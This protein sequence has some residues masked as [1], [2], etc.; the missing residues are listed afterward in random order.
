MT[1]PKMDEQALFKQLPELESQ[2]GLEHVKPLLERL[3]L[4]SLA[5]GEV[6]VRDQAPID[7]L[8]LVLAGRLRLSV[9][10]GEHA[11]Q[12][13]EVGPG[14][15]VGEL[16]YFS[17]VHLASSTVTACGDSEIARLSYR[18]FDA[19]LDEDSVAVCRL[20]HGFIQMLMRRLAVTANNPVIDPHGEMLLLGDLSVPWSELAQQPHGMI[21]FL[22]K[23]LGV[24]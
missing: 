24:H 11:V 13:G 20:T 7:A 2:L 21:D 4:R 12:L 6:L 9:E 10:F 1:E 23:L 16:G 18:D 3:S 22:K 8:Y 19:L 5:D 17:G 14:N 15:W